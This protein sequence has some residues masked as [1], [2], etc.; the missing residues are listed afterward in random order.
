MQLR[1][2]GDQLCGQGLS[3][4]TKVE[5][6]RRPALWTGV[7]KR[8]KLEGM[9][10]QKTSPAVEEAVLA[11]YVACG[12]YAETGRTFDMPTETVFSICTRLGGDE[13]AELRLSKRADLA[14]KARASIG[15]LITVVTPANCGTERSSRGLEAARAAGEL[16]RIAH[17]LA[18][19]EQEQDAAPT[20]INVYSGMRP[21]P[22]LEHEEHAVTVP[23][24]ALCAS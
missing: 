12:S 20:T 14:E 13:L 15:E 9:R 21:P 2:H 8:D 3:S 16:A 18:P 19:P 24:C 22:E 4:T 10:G 11:H 6:A 17:L 5:T 7:I 23:G 1:P